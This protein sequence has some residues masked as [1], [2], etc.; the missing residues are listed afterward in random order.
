M[1][2]SPSFWHKLGS[3][4][5]KMKKSEKLITEYTEYRE[6]M[7]SVL[8]FHHKQTTFNYWLDFNDL[9]GR[10]ATV[11]RVKEKTLT[12]LIEWAIVFISI[13]QS[14]RWKQF[15]RNYC[16]KHFGQLLISANLP[17]FHF[18]FKSNQITQA[19]FHALTTLTFQTVQT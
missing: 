17:I 6:F 15:N 11:K 12:Y 18:T 4:T 10:L 8:N 1:C 5:R 13:H 9:Q 7:V 2:F 3:T 19:H 14:I 16:N